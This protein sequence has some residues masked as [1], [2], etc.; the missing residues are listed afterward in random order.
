MIAGSLDHKLLCGY[1]A[2]FFGSGPGSKSFPIW[3]FGLFLRFAMLG[4]GL[5]YVSH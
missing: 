5:L 4:F 2:C 3:L 1:M